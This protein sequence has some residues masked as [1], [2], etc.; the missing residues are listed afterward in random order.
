M[1]KAI[2]TLKATITIAI[3][4]GMGIAWILAAVPI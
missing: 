1:R 2:D 4:A 3:L